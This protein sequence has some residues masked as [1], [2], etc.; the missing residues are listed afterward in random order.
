MIK[1]AQINSLTTMAFCVLLL[2]QI[3]GCGDGS[4]EADEDIMDTSGAPA[5][6]PDESM[7]VDLSAF[8]DGQALVPEIPVAGDAVHQSPGN[9]ALVAGDNYT[10]AAAR[11]LTINAAIA[12]ALAFPA[13]LFSL[14]K[15]TAP[16]KQSDGSWV[17]SYS[18]TYDVFAV[19]SMLI[20]VPDGDKTY[21]TMMVAVD[22]PILPITDFVW[23]TGMSTESNTSGSWKFNDMYAPTEQL[24][25]VKLD[26]SV[27]VLRENADLTIENID[28]RSDY[29]GDVLF[30]N[31]KPGIAAMSFEDIYEGETWDITW[32]VETGAGNITVPN[33]KSGE[34]SCWDAQ[35]QDIQCY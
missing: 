11:A 19:D 34:K 31:A 15:D 17:W 29:L 10:N 2:V 7:T 25:T 5:L 4:D 3:T 16:V 13:G 35:K 1:I 20:G 18:M 14:A 24:P 21:W 30:Y 9:V 32:D 6:P 8:N 27:D 22:N 12:S 26:W 28:T 23:Y 33:Y